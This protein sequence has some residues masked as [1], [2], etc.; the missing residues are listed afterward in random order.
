MGLAFTIIE[1]FKGL[2]SVFILILI[3]YWNAT[4]IPSCG[5]VYYVINSVIGV[6]ALLVYAYEAKG[7]K[8]R[9]RDEHCHV[10]RYMEEYYSK[11]T[12]DHGY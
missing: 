9:I 5:T 12:K 7:Y 3:F 4:A 8:N 11:I 1:I 10:Q 2:G 6:V